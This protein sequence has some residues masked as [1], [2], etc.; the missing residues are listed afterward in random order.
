MY[1][2]RRAAAKARKQLGVSRRN[3]GVMRAANV[4]VRACGGGRREQGCQ[5]E[6]SRKYGIEP[7]KEFR[8]PIPGRRACAC[9]EVARPCPAGGGF[10]RAGEA[11]EVGAAGRGFLSGA[12]CP[13]LRP[14]GNDGHHLFHPGDPAPRMGGKSAWIMA[15]AIR[16]MERE[17][18][19]RLDP[20]ARKD[21]CAFRM[22]KCGGAGAW[23]G[24]FFHWIVG[25][26]S[27]GAASV[28]AGTA[29]LSYPAARPGPA[30]GTAGAA[31][32]APLFSY[33][34]H[35]LIPGAPDR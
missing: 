8:R 9:P 31:P 11:G 24:V 30:P 7:V 3:R 16:I 21:E 10:G 32:D 33:R 15:G 13:T 17:C 29:I 35:A 14:P 12:P 2:S 27:K 1:L 20:G 25:G 4:P 5:G 19:H 28:L 34:A 22:Q 6:A 23:L 26:R 18:I